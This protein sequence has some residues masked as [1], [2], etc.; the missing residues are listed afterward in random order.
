MRTGVSKPPAR[1]ESLRGL[2][3]AIQEALA[4]GEPVALCTVVKAEG[5]APRE[6]GAKMLVC[7]DGTTLGTVGG[8]AMEADVARQALEALRQNASC[9]ADYTLRD[10][11]ADPGI[12]GGQA[13]I[14]IDVLTP[15]PTLLIVGAGHIGQMLAQM[16]RLQGY[17]IAVCDDRAEYANPETLPAADRILAGPLPEVLTDIAITP[18]TYVVIVTRGHK[19]D[20]A[21]LGYLLDKGAGYLGMIGSTRKVRTVFE[22]LR[23]AGAT[24]EQLARVRAPIGLRIG[25][26][27]PAE[28]ALCILAEI[29]QVRRGG[30]AQSL[31]MTPPPGQL[32]RPTNGEK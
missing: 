24:E 10:E 30:D 13:S 2:F 17:R 28:I 12:C 22:H 26:Q 1:G 9:L 31:S 15:A 3:A 32:T 5:G 27:T 29:L 14:F 11:G 19:D 7:A 25:A 6:P 8:G 18:H 21:A 16:G 4:H 23:A 20:E